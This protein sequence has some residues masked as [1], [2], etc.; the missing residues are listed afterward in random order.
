MEAGLPVIC[1][2]SAGA[3]MLIE[4][5]VSGFLFDPAKPEE[6]ANFFKLVLGMSEAERLKMGRNSQDA[7]K[8]HLN[9]ERIL[10]LLEESYANAI[11]RGVMTSKEAWLEALLSEGPEQVV[12]PKFNLAQRAIRKVGRI[13][14]HV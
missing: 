3:E 6:L 9:E 12:P 8:T 11:K 1:S 5:G 7:V 2:K 10:N 13:L 14:A 4:D